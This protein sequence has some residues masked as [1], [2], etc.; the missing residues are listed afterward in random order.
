MAAQCLRIRA[1]RLRGP[2]LQRCQPVGR[3]IDEHDKRAA[4]T[5]VLKPGVRAAVDLDQFTKARTPL[6]RAKHPRL[7]PLLRSPETEHDLHLP[8]RLHRGRDILSL[9]QLLGCQGRTK[10]RILLLRKH[11]DRVPLPRR[12]PVVRSPAAPA[13]DQTR[14]LMLPPQQH[15]TLHLANP[16]PKTLRRPHAAT[17]HPPASGRS[18]ATDP[19]P[20]GSSENPTTPSSSSSHLRAKGH[21]DF[22]ER[23]H[24]YSGLILRA[25]RLTDHG[26]GLSYWGRENSYSSS[27]RRRRIGPV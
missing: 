27:Q 6:A 7:T 19:T 12:K 16:D 3:G 14:V 9:H 11:P 18:R 17:G 5:V 2:E 24:S 4:R 21:S 10:V 23:G 25:R 8:H 13:P 1:H 22:G 15:Q 26:R 20:G